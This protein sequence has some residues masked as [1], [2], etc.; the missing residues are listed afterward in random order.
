MQHIEWL[1]AARDDGNISEQAFQKIMWENVNEAL[2][3]S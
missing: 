3:L 2:E 1:T